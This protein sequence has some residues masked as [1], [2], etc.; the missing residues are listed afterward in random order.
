MKY[1]KSWTNDKNV[2]LLSQTAHHTK[3]ID[4]SHRV[5][6]FLKADPTVLGTMYKV[7]QIQIQ[8]S[9]FLFIIHILHR[10][11]ETEVDWIG[12]WLWFQLTSVFGVRPGSPCC[13]YI[14]GL[15]HRRASIQTPNT[16]QFMKIAF[17]V[18]SVVQSLIKLQRKA[19]PSPLSQLPMLK[20]INLLITLSYS[21]AD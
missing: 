13:Q 1:A 10:N 9:V 14:R 5:S 12:L 18:K 8:V 17:T 15:T 7:I 16:S 19:T 21:I 4:T 20:L 2:I 11:W 6:S 3:P